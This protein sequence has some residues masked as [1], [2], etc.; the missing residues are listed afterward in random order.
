[1]K[2][3]LFLDFD[4]VL[5]FSMNALGQR[6]SSHIL[7]EQ[8]LKNNLDIDVVFSTD[9][10]NNTSFEDLLSRFSSSIRDRFIGITPS[11]SP[12]FFKR[13]KEI[14]AFVASIQEESLFVALDDR[15]DLFSPTCNFLALVKH[16]DC[17]C[18]KMEDLEKVLALFE[19]QSHARLCS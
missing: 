12:T 3:I 1:M 14:L 10:R 18:L 9:W 15:R 7:L 6:H 19:K 11:I 8:F 16:E 5:V 17:N 13:E 2:K 4:G